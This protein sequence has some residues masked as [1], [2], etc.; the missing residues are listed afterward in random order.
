MQRVGVLGREGS[1]KM[2]DAGGSKFDSKSLPQGLRVVLCF[3]AEVP[4]GRDATPLLP[5][6]GGTLLAEVPGRRIRDFM[7][8]PGL[9]VV[10]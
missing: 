2:N 4:A 8:S 7:I 6:A 3:V 9:R 10:L 1:F 5:A